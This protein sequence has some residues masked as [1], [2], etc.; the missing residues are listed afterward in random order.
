[1]KLVAA[2]LRFQSRKVNSFT[3]ERKDVK[4]KQIHGL[5]SDFDE[6]EASGDCYLGLFV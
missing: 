4:T 1:M 5:M 3:R 6:E 2:E